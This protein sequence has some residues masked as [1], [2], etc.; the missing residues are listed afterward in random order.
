MS[1]AKSPFKDN[2]ELKR[3]IG[4]FLSAHGA[5]LAQE[6]KRT[7][8]FFELAAYNDLVK[9]YETNGFVMKPMNLKGR[10]RDFIYALSPSAKPTS[11]S[12]FQAKKS[13]SNGDI[14]RYEIRHNVRIRSAHD[15]DIYITPDYAVIDKDSLESVRLKHYYNGKADY[16]FVRSDCVRTFAETKHYA[17][18]PELVLNFVGVVNEIK[19]DFMT[20]KFPAKRPRHCGPSLF[21]SGVGNPHLLKI[22]KSLADRY[23]INVF[24]GLFAYPSQ[25]YSS[26]NQPNVKK[27]GSR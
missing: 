13:Y 6:A 26:R 22:K 12:Y 15:N 16:W 5:N 18:S 1:K 19:P 24:L 10:G 4:A 23:R 21:V 20:G 9:Y 7:S 27:I 8:S 14:W 3:Q 11:C 2:A 25:V 17:P